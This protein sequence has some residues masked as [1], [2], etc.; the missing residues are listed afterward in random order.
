MLA[1]RMRERETGGG[2]S[3]LLRCARGLNGLAAHVDGPRDLTRPCCEAAGTV[4]L[5]GTL[6]A[7]SKGL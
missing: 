7:P 1:R 4:D 5:G 3:W 2:R 6:C